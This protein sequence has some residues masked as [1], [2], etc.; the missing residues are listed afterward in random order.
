MRKLTENQKNFIADIFFKV[1][2]KNNNHK[3][4]AYKLL[5][6]GSCYV[7]GYNPIW[8][9]GI[10]NFIETERVD[11]AVDC[12][13]YKFDIDNFLS[14]LFY[15]ENHVFYI[16]KLLGVKNELDQKIN[17]ISDLK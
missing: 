10:G 13:L 9:G 6:Q 4:I 3:Q 1:G 11:N 14:S 8:R 7:G 17:E 15:K 2:H 5:E 16:A 12:L